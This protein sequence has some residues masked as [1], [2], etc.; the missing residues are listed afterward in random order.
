MHLLNHSPPSIE[1]VIAVDAGGVFI[2]S[3]AGM[4]DE[5]ALSND[6]AHAA[7]G[8]SPVIARDILTRHASGR[9]GAGHRGH[10]DAV[11]QVETTDPSGLK[12][13]VESVR[14]FHLGGRQIVLL[15][16]RGRMETTHSKMHPYVIHLKL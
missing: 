15:Q 6:E 4:R 14:E 10:R 3:R 12:Q 8:S 1:S 11:A 7:L 13:D 5:R 2:V 9:H 16:G